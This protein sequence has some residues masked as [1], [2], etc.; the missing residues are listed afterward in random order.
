MASGLQAKFDT[1]GWAAGLDRLLGP[2]RVS[3]AR[4]M[5]VAGGE[6]LRDDAKARVNIVNGVLANAIY[7]AFREARSN[8]KEVQ[9]A[10]TWNKSKAPHGH[11][12]EFGHWQ[13]YAV[14]RKP[15]GTYV[16]DKRR[17]L[18]TPKWVPAYPFL[19]PAYE[20]ASSRAHAAMIARGRQRLP[21]LLAGQGARNEP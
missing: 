10:V 16:T 11:L 9:Y 15:D 18:V 6:V 5:A 17:K 2:A 1:S 20:A 3:L 19:R 7:L 21:E 13:I 12:V 4:S 8:D 14:V